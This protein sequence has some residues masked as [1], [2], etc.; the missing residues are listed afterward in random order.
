MK[1]KFREDGLRDLRMDPGRLTQSDLEDVYWKCWNNFMTFLICCAATSAGEQQAFNFMN[2]LMD[3][4]THLKHFSVPV[5]TSL[6]IAVCADDDAYIPKK[7]M[8]SL[9]KIWPG[10]EV[11]YVKGGHVRAYVQY[12]KE[13]RYVTN[14]N[15]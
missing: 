10:A 5:D 7:G 6:T 3:E 12:Q 11:R 14:L 4:C 2:G 15:I 13:F 9:D 1:S 8:S